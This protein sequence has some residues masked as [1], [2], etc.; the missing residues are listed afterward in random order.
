MSVDHPTVSVIIAAYNWSAA[1][2]LAVDSVLLQTFLD[3]EILV[4]GDCCTDDSQAVVEGFEDPRLRWFNLPVHHRSQSAPNNFGLEQAR[5]DYIAYLGQDDIWWPTHLAALVATARAASADVVASLTIMYGPPGSG[6][7]AMTG[8]FPN[9]G[10]SP[11]YFFPPSSMLHTRSVVMEGARWRSPAE[12]LVA[13]DVD[14]VEILRGRG[15]KF[16]S[17]SELTVFKFNASWRR[18]SYRRKSLEEQADLLNG[19]RTEGEAFRQRQLMSVLQ[20]VTE[21]RFVRTEPPLAVDRAAAM[22]MKDWQAFKG[23]HPR[24]APARVSSLPHGLKFFNDEPYVGFEWHPVEATG[25]ERWRWTGPSTRS[26]FYLPVRID[27]PSRLKIRVLH[28]LQE[29]AFAEASL[30][31]GERRLDD[32]RDRQADGSW[33]W[34]AVLDP[35]SHGGPIDLVTIVYPRPARAIDL[36][37][38]PDRRWLGVRVGDIDLEE[39]HERDLIGD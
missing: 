19:I 29:E 6:I 14:F 31:V 35:T 1:L 12:A 25:A 7:R 34:S 23:S 33:I 24:D 30:M 39:L 27:R 2:K 5:G 9:A 20:A 17:T 15:L 38:S 36:D 4:V 26:S 13:V 8:L 3:Y 10:Y 16:A 28:V 37:L 21:E 18:N 32:A 11:M 22:N